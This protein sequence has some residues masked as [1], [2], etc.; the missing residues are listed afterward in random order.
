MECGVFDNQGIR[1]TYEGE[2]V[3]FTSLTSAMRF[4]KEI[5]AKRDLSS[6]KRYL[7]IRE[8]K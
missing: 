6:P 8:I 5:E 7:C 4:I 1:Q 3:S 2:Q